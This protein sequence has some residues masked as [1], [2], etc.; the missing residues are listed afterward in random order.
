MELKIGDMWTVFDDV[1]LFCITTNETLTKRGALVMGAGI[2]RQA[3]DRFSGIDLRFGQLVAN[4]DQ[5]YGL[6]VLPDYPAG[7]LAAFQVKHHFRSDASL[8]LIARSTK[9]L[10]DWCS[11]HPEAKVALNFP[12]IGL[13]NLDEETVLPIIDKLP[14]QVQVWKYE[15]QSRT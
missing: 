12:G 10:I 5:P 6:L 14:E 7:K 13:G 4:L 11:I 2:A 8:D 1:D 3:R 9:M 15:K